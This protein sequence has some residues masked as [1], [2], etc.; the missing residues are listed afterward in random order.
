MAKQKT[1]VMQEF[2]AHRNRAGFDNLGIL[3]NLLAE[4]GLRKRTL[5]RMDAGLPVRERSVWQAYRFLN[6]R[7]K[8]EGQEPIPMD[9]VLQIRPN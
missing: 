1:A 7:L 5:Q 2:S 3:Q 9:A 4:K 8:R 6:K